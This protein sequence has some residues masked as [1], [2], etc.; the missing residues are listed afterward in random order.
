[1]GVDE[2]RN[3]YIYDYLK[4]DQTHT[5]ILLNGNWGSGKTYYV[6]RSLIPYIEQCSDGNFA[7]SCYKRCIYVSLYGVKSAEELSKSIL[8]ES[9]LKLLNTKAGI[10][11]EGVAKTLIKRAADELSIDLNAG[12]Q[13]WN[14]LKKCANLKNKLLILDDVERHDPSF[15]VVEIMG[16]V[17]NLCEQDGVKVLMV[18]DEKTLFSAE[19][20]IKDSGKYK[21]IKEKTIGDTLAFVP[22]EMSVL[23]SILASFKLAFLD[24]TSLNV[25][26]EIRTIISSEKDFEW[27]FRAI[28]RACQKMSDICRSDIF[29]IEVKESPLFADFLAE[30]LLGLIAFYLRLAKDAA[31]RWGTDTGLVSQKL[32]T[33][34]FPLQRFAYD[35]C[36]FHSFEGCSLKATAA[37]NEYLSKK[38]FEKSNGYINIIERYYRSNESELKK[39]LDSIKESIGKNSVD[40]SNFVGLASYLIAIEYDLG[41]KTDEILDTMVS[42]VEADPKIQS[43]SSLI[44]PFHSFGL[45][46]KAECDAL[47]AFEARLISAAKKKEV[48]SSRAFISEKNIEAVLKNANDNATKWLGS[49]EGYSHF[50]SFEAL[51]DFIKSIECS[52]SDLDNIRGLFFTFYRGIHDICDFC[53]KDIEPLENLKANVDSLLKNQSFDKVKLLQLRWFSSNLKEFVVTIKRR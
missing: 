48:Q 37:F 19:P 2:S 17:N 29:S 41:L 16:F 42:A 22:D 51:F 13:A 5:A 38:T 10:F 3:T 35:Y 21:T 32:G 9:R 47:A 27:N 6:K 4:K 25:P 15:G 40:S 45:N 30:T 14:R 11:A 23:R 53:S 1:M 31:L 50:L 52:A 7:E 33:D 49:K 20:N 36:Q 46:S 24:S 44:N 43:R 8:I 18:C 28:A 34:K 39:A 12:S 26:V